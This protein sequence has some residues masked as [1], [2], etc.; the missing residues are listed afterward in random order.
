MDK[1]I[2]LIKKLWKTKIIRF[3]LVAGLN[4][5][6]GYSLFAFLIWV[7]LHYTLAILVGQFVGALFNFKTYGILVFENKNN[8]L[9]FKFFGVYAFM[10]LCNTGG[11][12]AL[13]YLFDFNDYIT[14]AILVIPVGLLGFIINKTFVF[15]KKKTNTE[16]EDKI[17]RQVEEMPLEEIGDFYHDIDLVEKEES[18]KN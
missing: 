15:S 4:I 9:I 18:P 17:I 2:T 5:V 3:F 13:K 11:M 10:W 8:K 6:F 14:G 7:G 1:V 12:T 16:M